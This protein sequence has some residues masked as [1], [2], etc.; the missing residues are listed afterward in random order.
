MEKNRENP[1]IFLNFI[2]KSTLSLLYIFTRF[3][4]MRIERQVQFKKIL[5]TCC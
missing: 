2:T 3:G 1:E 4:F 5:N